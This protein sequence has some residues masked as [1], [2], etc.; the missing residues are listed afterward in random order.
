M[1]CAVVFDLEFTAWPGS[2]EHRWLRPGEFREVVQI[3]AVKIDAETFAETAAFDVLIKPRLNPVLSSYL[4]NLTGVTN[5]AVA[6]RG[7][8]FAV[9]YRAFIRFADG[10]PLLAFGRDD[11][12]LTDNLELYGLKDEPRLPPYVNAVP[13]LI[14]AGIDPSG[15]HAC[16]IA[17]AAGATFAGRRHDALD[18]AR[19]VAL[20]IKTLVARGA[21]NLLLMEPPLTW[22]EAAR[23]VSTIA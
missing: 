23:G 5:A 4:E 6:E 9:A 2:M 18:D 11:L 3:G 12:V 8:D 16:D 21:P 22:R 1:R 17:E 15:L 19:S 13:W 20:G 10:A 7:V 14:E